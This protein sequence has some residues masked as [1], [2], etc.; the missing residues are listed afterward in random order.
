MQAC[1]GAA[2]QMLAKSIELGSQANYFFGD[3]FP[4]YL[5]EQSRK[6]V[7]LDSS[8]VGSQ[9]RLFCETA[10]AFWASLGQFVLVWGLRCSAPAPV[11]PAGL[12]LGSPVHSQ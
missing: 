10:G 7:H 6:H 8:R 1:A 11:R 4:R 5:G 9:G 12:Q 3:R 2:S